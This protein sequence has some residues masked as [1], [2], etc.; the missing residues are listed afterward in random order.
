MRKTPSLY[1]ANKVGDAIQSFGDRFC[2]HL[3]EEIDTLAPDKLRVIFIPQQ[4]RSQ[5]YER[6]DDN[7]EDLSRH[8]DM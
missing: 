2:G 5:K 1:E 4:K 7:V 3:R 8:Q 6:W